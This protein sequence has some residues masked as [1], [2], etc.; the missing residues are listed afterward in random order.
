VTFPTI[1]FE[2]DEVTSG[3]PSPTTV[4]R[5]CDLFETH[6]AVRLHHVFPPGFLD[7]LKAHVLERYKRELGGTTKEDRRPLYS[8]DLVGPPGQPAYYAN[9]MLVPILKRVLG[10]DFVIGAVSTVISFPGS[11]QQFVH[12]DSPS[13]FDD[14]AVDV[15]LPTYALT[16][17]VPMVDANTET[18]STRVWPG[19]HRVVDL[20]QAQRMPSESP[21]VPFGSILMTD[22]RVVHCGSPNRSNRVRPLLYTSYHR[23]WFRDWGGYEHRPPVRIGAAER[24]QVPAELAHMFRVAD[25][26][27]GEPEGPRSL[28]HR[29][30]ATVGWPR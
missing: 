18:G 3:R 1:G 22:S 6:G 24:R 16:V 27:S 11:P 4:D 17:L 7:E 5:V 26:S 21:D 8:V 13:L 29:L 12:R 9:P 2:P 25:E 15:E 19:T 10:D 28:M 30:R 20:E 14:L 23:N